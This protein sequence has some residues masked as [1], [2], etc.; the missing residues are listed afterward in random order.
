MNFTLELTD[1]VDED[2]RKLILAPLVEYNTSQA[3]PSNGKPVVI[4]MKDELGAVVGGL[5]G[6][7]GYEWL[8]TQLLVVP[9]S[10]RGTGMGS[11]LMAM[12][13]N[14]AVARGCA[15]VWL[16]TFEFQARGFYERIGYEV[17]AELGNCPT[18]Y[19]RY[20]MKKSLTA[21]AQLRGSASAEPHSNFKA[22]T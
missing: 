8:F 4:T 13:E 11:Q 15:G 21:A 7:T 17:F 20:F 5:W 9:E 12:A 14:E 2:T 16:D 22:T 10:H 6:H 19:S 18:G 1:A 3:G